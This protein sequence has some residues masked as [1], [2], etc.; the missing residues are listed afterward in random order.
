MRIKSV[1]IIALL[2]C[3]TMFSQNAFIGGLFDK[4][5][6]FV[7]TNPSKEVFKGQIV[8]GQRNGVGVLKYKNGNVF[9]GDFYRNKI[10]GYGMLIADTLSFVKNCDKCVAYVGNW[11][12]G[13]KT[14]YGRCYDFEG[15][16]LYQGIFE[17]D[18]PVNSY[19]FPTDSVDR[20]FIISLIDENTVYLGETKGGL[21]DGYGVL[22]FPS[23]DCWVSSFK[24]DSRYGV[25][26]YLT[27]DN[28]WEMIDVLNGEYAMISS[29]QR[30]KQI[31]VETEQRKQLLR[32]TLIGT[33][34][35]LA[36]Q[37]A[38][39]ASTV[40]AVKNGEQIVGEGLDATSGKSL[41]SGG[42]YQL[43]YNKWEK[44][45]EK[46]YNSLTKLGYSKESKSEV[47]GGTGASMNGG[48][49][50]AQKR[51]FR[52]AQKEMKKIREK[53]K[54]AGVIITQSKWETATIN[55]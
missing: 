11:K 8:K 24:N 12:N 47:S 6:E 3:P 23:G 51:S 2:L 38:E 15:N 46:H 40:S 39:F 33:L 45:A 50:V 35:D 14:G 22:V 4:S 9:V 7:T 27:Y 30:Y 18:K 13:K 5:F 10:S 31:D 37:S 52:D 16:V 49:Y 54:K 25:G 19:P 34:S 36:V 53:A 29:S 20:S 44:R 26:V 42:N 41:S 17:N 28:E 55:Y 43:M 1:V 48:N 21:F 32:Q